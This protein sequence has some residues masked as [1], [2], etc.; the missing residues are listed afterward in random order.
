M[1]MLR[2]FMENPMIY[3]PAPDEHVPFRTFWRGMRSITFVFSARYEVTALNLEL[4][5]A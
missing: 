2:E 4:T 1:M 3:P 5:D